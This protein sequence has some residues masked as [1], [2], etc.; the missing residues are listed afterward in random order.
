MADTLIFLDIDGVLN[1]GVRDASGGPLLL[2]E[3]NLALARR[4]HS[5]EFLGAHGDAVA[6][7]KQ[8]DARFGDLACP[9]C[10]HFSPVLVRRFVDILRAAGPRSTVVLS[11]CWRRRMR[12]WR[13]KR[14]EREISEQLGTHFEFHEATESAEEKEPGDRLFCIG[15]YVAQRCAS[16]NAHD[17]RIVI[18]ED[19]FIA[20]VDGW[21]CRGRRIHDVSSAEAYVRRR[22]R[23]AAEVKLVHCYEEWAM[24]SGVR[25]QVGAGLSE[26]DVG[27]TLQF[28]AAPPAAEKPRLGLRAALRSWFG[29]GCDAGART[30][31]REAQAMAEAAMCFSG[32]AGVAP[33]LCIQM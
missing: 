2:S 13:V 29:G 14:L 31:V 32:V 28:L 16:G 23:R 21:R 5:P 8:V 9:G 33:V 10:D 1:V 25:V 6:K 3:G 27:A 4:D 30:G 18:L 24:D 7:I 12:G 19:F 20:P 22:A 15:N 11:S 26:A 17:L